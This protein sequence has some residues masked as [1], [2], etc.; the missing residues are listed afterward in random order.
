M[1]HRSRVPLPHLLVIGGR[2]LLGSHIV[3]A[4]LAHRSHPRV[5]VA[6]RSPTGNLIDGADYYTS[7]ISNQ[8]AFQT[9]LSTIRPTIVIN[10]ASP[11]AKAGAQ[12]STST[13]I[14]STRL[15]LTCAA[16]TPFVNTISISPAAPL[17]QEL[18]SPS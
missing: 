14:G 1:E 2:G 4:L 7:D 16:E 15:S 17:L 10:T 9:L 11:L 5:S 13:T 6:S 8:A 3:Q 12:D 18:P